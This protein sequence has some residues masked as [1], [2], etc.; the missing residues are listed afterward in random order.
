MSEPSPCVCGH[1]IE[2]HPL[3]RGCQACPVADP[4]EWYEPEDS[5]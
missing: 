1:A 4:C 5:P 2:E 3:R